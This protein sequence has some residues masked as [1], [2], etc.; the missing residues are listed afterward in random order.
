MFGNNKPIAITMLPKSA[1]DV[2]LPEDFIRAQNAIAV[3]K[4]SF[5]KVTTR[6]IIKLFR[7]ARRQPV[8]GGYDYYYDYMANDA[9]IAELKTR[10]SKDHEVIASSAADTG[11]LAEAINGPGLTIGRVCEQI[12]ASPGKRK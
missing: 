7:L 3:L 5:D 12:S 4:S 10:A 9:I 11:R 6:E 1:Q 8:Y 2:P